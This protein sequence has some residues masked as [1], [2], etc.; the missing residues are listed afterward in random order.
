VV[1]GSAGHSIQGLITR[2]GQAQQVSASV[3][4]PIFDFAPEALDHDTVAYKTFTGPSFSADAADTPAW[5]SWCP[6][7]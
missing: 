6:S 1:A 7:C 4:A 5:Q 3:V 2:P